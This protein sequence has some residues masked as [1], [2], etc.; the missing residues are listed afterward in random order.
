MQAALIGVDTTTGTTT[1]AE[2]SSGGPNCGNFCQYLIDLFGQEDNTQLERVLGGLIEPI[3]ELL[4]IVV[5]AVIARALLRRVVGSVV[6]RAKTGTGEPTALHRLGDFVDG[7]HDAVAVPSERRIR[8]A[9]SMGALALSIGTAVIWTVAILMALGALGQNIAPLIAGAGIVGIALGFG[10][11]DLVKDFLSGVFMLIEDQ[12]GVGDVVDVGDAA[13]VVEG[14]SLRTTRI[15]DVEGK[16]WHVPNGEI[17]RVA[18]AS[19]AWAR[20]L[21]D[22]DVAY[23]ADIDQA[24]KVIEEVGA[25]LNA[26]EDWTEFI[27]EDPEVWG[28]QNLGADSV[29]LRV[30][31]KTVAG[32]QFKIGRELRR[33]IKYAMDAEGIEIPFQQRTVWVRREDGD[34]PKKEDAKAAATSKRTAKRKSRS[35]PESSKASTAPGEV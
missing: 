5:L 30:V 27:L 2:T 22:V 9:E 20:A 8:R 16:L 3:V 4:V 13:G 7:G 23:G 28:V 25:R 11:Q 33:R 31:I 19:Q 29:Q 15:R 6:E 17:R 14:V 32:E 10:A 35:T 1:A 18:N 34:G 24:I 12:Y 21:L 26:D